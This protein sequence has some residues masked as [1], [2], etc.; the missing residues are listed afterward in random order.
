MKTNGISGILILSIFI[1]SFLQ[2][3]AGQEKTK[4][5]TEKEKELRMLEEIDQQKKAIAEKKKAFD[6]ASKLSE[7][8]MK[9]IQHDIQKA[10]NQAEEMSK[11]NEWVK[12]YRGDIGRNFPFGES[13]VFTP[14]MNNFYDQ[15]FMGDSERTSWE[16]T[17]SIKENT[18]S[19][20][21]IFEVEKN[22]RNVS[23]AVNGDC[24]SGEIRIKIV[25]PN[26]KTYSDIVIDEFGNLN[27]RKSFSITE[28]ENR[29]KL[30]K[31]KFQIN[32]SKATG[33]FRIS[34]QAY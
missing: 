17:K 32:A 18:I 14:G 26:G 15:F 27:W 12:M 33:F 34:V 9:K 8:Q 4:E 28:E 29:D 1:S 30:G 10:G 19:N 5:E 23:M 16:F 21:Y 31:W 22:V 13:F 25:M 6:E 2:P 20:E 3:A 11:V 24:K 7:E